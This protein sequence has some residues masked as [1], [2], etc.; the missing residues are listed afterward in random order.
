[1]KD[2]RI[3]FSEDRLQLNFDVIQGGR[4]TKRNLTVFHRD[5][6]SVTIEY[7]REKAGFKDY[8][9]ER[10]VIRTKKQRAPIIY[11]GIKEFEWYDNYKNGLR[12]FALD[13]KI[14]L[15]DEEVLT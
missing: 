15:I 5:I 9:S 7:C 4:T 2:M 6:E 8:D 10:I 14:E 12:K 13:N 11:Y 3:K 1:M